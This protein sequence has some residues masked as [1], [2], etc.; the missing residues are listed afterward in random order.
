MTAWPAVSRFSSRLGSACVYACLYVHILCMRTCSCTNGSTFDDKRDCIVIIYS[1]AS[2]CFS[3]NDR[4]Q[5]K[6]RMNERMNYTEAI[7]LPVVNDGRWLIRVKKFTSLI[8]TCVRPKR[9]KHALTWWPCAL[10]LSEG[11]NTLSL[12]VNLYQTPVCRSIWLPKSST[13]V[14]TRL[15]WSRAAPAAAI[16]ILMAS[17]ADD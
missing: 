1:A 5:V 16:K 6:G 4:Y 13:V 9:E 10:S 14:R 8:W 12:P 11:N 3:P 2:M 17:A 15:L 7:N